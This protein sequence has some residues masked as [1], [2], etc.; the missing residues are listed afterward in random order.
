MI[1]WNR[2]AQT[3]LDDLFANYMEELAHAD[4][5][6]NV[7]TATVTSK[8]PPSQIDPF[9]KFTFRFVLEY[10]DDVGLFGKRYSF[11]HFSKHEYWIEMEFGF[12][13]GLINK[14]TEYT[15]GIATQ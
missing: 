9:P 6:T 1:F 10:L 12:F 2:P 5:P 7:F 8:G 4:G 15:N 3:I 13:A 14:L 11:E